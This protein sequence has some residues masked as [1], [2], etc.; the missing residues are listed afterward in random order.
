MAGPRLSSC[1]KIWKP[2]GKTMNSLLTLSTG[3]TVS[4]LGI[5]IHFVFLYRGNITAN[6]SFLLYLGTT[7]MVLWVPK[8][9]GLRIC[10]QKKILWQSKKRLS[11]L[12]KEIWCSSLCNRDLKYIF[13][14]SLLRV[15]LRSEY[16]FQRW[17]AARVFWKSIP[18]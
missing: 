14:Q 9:S 13:L 15:D 16:R 7:R 4:P 18:L 5:N 11:K 10:Q 1:E 12:W 6:T 3:P 8:S 2:R 17:G